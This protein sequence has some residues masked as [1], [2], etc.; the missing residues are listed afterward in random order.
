LSGLLPLGFWRSVGHSQNGF[1]TECFLDEV[2][3]AGGKGPYELRRRLLSKQ[4]WHL[5]VL[6]VAAAKTGWSAPL[7]AG[8][9]RGIA[10][11]ESFGSFVAQ[12][13]EASLD[14]T[15]GTVRVHRVVCAVDCG[16]YVNPDTVAAMMEGGIVY[17]L[18]AALKGAITINKGRVEQSNFQDYDML[19]MNEMPRVEVHIVPSK[20]VPGG[21]GEAGT[22]PIAPAVCNAIFAATGKPIRRLPIRPEDLA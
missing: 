21:T 4:P 16:R 6:D 19:R 10:V 5:G 22:P 20:E 12:V 3:R 7:P 17:G 8:R 15:A 18:T 1:V 11:M 9:S 14:R 13:A 2:A